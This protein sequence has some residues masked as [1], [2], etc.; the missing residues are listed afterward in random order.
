MDGSG[1]SSEI[2]YVKYLTQCLASSK[3][4]TN[5]R[6]VDTVIIVVITY[7]CVYQP[8]WA[9]INKVVKALGLNAERNG[10]RHGSS[11]QGPD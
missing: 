5:G 6:I 2:I 10:I 1:V 11:N 9:S 3:H 8:V 4:S 7:K